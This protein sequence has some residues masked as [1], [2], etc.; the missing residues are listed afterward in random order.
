MKLTRRSL[1]FGAA[2]WRCARLAA[3]P[4]SQTEKRARQVIDDA[5][6]AL[7]GPKFLAMQDRVETGRAYSFYRDS[8]SGLSQAKIFTRYIPVPG[9]KTGDDLGVQEREAFGKNEEYGYVLFREDKGWEVTYRGP[10]EIE[11]ER[12]E[13]YRRTTLNDLFYILRVRLREPGLTFD[14]RGGD[15]ADNVPVDIVDIVDS[16][17]RT[18]S[19]YFHSITKLPVREQWVWRDPKTRERNEE[20]TRF[21]LYQNAGG[22]VQWPAQI[23]RERNGEKIYQIFSESVAVNQNLGDDVFAIPTGPATR[24]PVKPPKK[25]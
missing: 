23:Q 11:D 7:G 24:T 12:W 20:I 5:V 25:K 19:A 1:M 15:V 21:T 9:G 2:G 18:V 22:G 8:I 16:Q 3:Q 17:N 4:L 6:A 13:R 10:N 14:S